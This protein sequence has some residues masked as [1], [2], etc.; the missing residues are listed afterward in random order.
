MLEQ[1]DGQLGRNNA[2]LEGVIVW[3]KALK[4]R[5]EANARRHLYE[6]VD[7]TARGDGTRR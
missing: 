4:L 5:G 7:N 6:D 1:G 2:S 3:T